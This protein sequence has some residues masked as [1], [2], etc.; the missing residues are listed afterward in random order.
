MVIS[1]SSNIS[2]L[3]AQRALSGALNH[4]STL[5]QRL[6]SGSRINSA[7]DDP[8]SLAVSE[9]L[10]VSSRINE[11]AVRNLNDGISLL[12]VTEGAVTQLK[13]VV[14]RVTEL[15][16]QSA[17][18]TFS[19][20]QRQALDREAQALA[21]EY[22]RIVSTTS[23]NGV[24]IFTQ[25]TPLQLQAGSSLIE[26]RPPSLVGI[27]ADGS[28]GGVSILS[29]NGSGTFAVGRSFSTSNMAFT[30]GVA[31]F[32]G[33][34]RLDLASEDGMHI[35]NGDGTFK[36]K[37]NYNQ[38]GAVST[39]DVDNDGRADI[40]LA[41]DSFGTAAD[42]IRVLRSNGDGTFAMSIRYDVG[43]DITD[44]SVADFN[45]DGNADIATSN[46]IDDTVSIIF[47]NGDG[48]FTSCTSYGLQFAG[49]ITTADL[50]GDGHLDIFG[51]NHDLQ[52][53]YGNGNGT[54]KSSVT[55]YSTGVA[56]VFKY[57]AGDMN[58]DGA[59]DLVGSDYTTPSELRIILGNG[60][61][62]FKNA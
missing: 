56:Q 32:N 33:D 2:G 34:G 30:L 18:G 17:N 6:S 55:A 59:L 47:G 5:F 62:T 36:A 13:S 31:D 42:G 45:G 44:P 43:G 3:K 60:D 16:E 28:F 22:A 20:T 48:T 7:S 4:Q 46:Y 54:F 12:N 40:I 52:V 35:G 25:S 1:L 19:N 39:G 41:Q 26:F 9:G 10:R 23:F 21:K 8:A 53:L 24:N 51:G 11:K 14:T 29:G 38:S 27:E 58:G 15:A 37:I 50:N 57:A 49:E 61:G